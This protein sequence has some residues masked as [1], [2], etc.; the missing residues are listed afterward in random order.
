MLVSGIF[1]IV[2][3]LERQRSTEVRTWDSGGIEETCIREEKSREE[4]WEGMGTKYGM[5]NILISGSLF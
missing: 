5:T 4:R 3:M 2:A 1:S